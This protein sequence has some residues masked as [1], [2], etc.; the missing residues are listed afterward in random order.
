MDKKIGSILFFIS[1]MSTVL[2]CQDQS[3]LLYVKDAEQNPIRQ[4]EK[5]VPFLFQVVVNSNGEKFQK[6]EHIAGMDNFTVQEA[7]DERSV[8][9]ING[10]RSERTTYNYILK[11]NT[12]GSFKFG[13]VELKNNKGE[14]IK[15]EAIRFHV[16][17]QVVGHH[18]KRQPYFLQIDID[19]KSLYVG[20]TLVV[21]VR[22]Y[23]VEEFQNLRIVKPD[24]DGFV[25][26]HVTKDPVS[27]TDKIHGKEYRYQEWEMK[28]YPEK[29]GTIL[30]PPYQAVFMMPA[31]FAQGLMGVFDMLSMSS[32]RVVQSSARSVD[33]IALPDSAAFKD[34]T[35]VGD[36]DKASLV[37]NKSEGDV[38]EGLVATLSVVGNGNVESFKAPALHL[39]NGL[40]YYESN[41]F[42]RELIDGKHEKAFEY[43]LQA[44]HEGDFKVPEQKFSYFD[45]KKKEYRSLQTSA[46][47]LKINP[48]SLKKVS[49][50]N[51]NVNPVE[52]AG[53]K[54]RYQFKE[55][56]L[57]FVYESGFGSPYRENILHDVFAWL[58]ILFLWAALFTVLYWGYSLY[59]GI[60]L[61]DIY[62]IY[63]GFVYFKALQ[64]RRAQDINGLYLLL[65]K[66]GRRYGVDLFGNDLTH[67]LNQAAKKDSGMKGWSE[68]LHVI[69]S[70][71]F[72]LD[73]KNS[74]SQGYVLQNSMYWLQG[75]L[76]YVRYKKLTISSSFSL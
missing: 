11:G 47:H 48:S 13:P 26:E 63:Y 69:T 8:T 4:A 1:F 10:Q 24:L 20:E 68:F 2:L 38:G 18:V 66:V 43:V 60:S 29:V 31:N 62:W 25:V 27:G 40:K 46:V 76:Y 75:L 61:L 32:E 54:Q 44:D 59:I 51:D 30:I 56:E 28:L 64:L 73:K 16:G 23:F 55:G 52:P 57:D 9:I 3:V 49:V 6:P 17:D 39:P 7:Q 37:I 53:E 22:F 41:S 42:V 72:S 58:L 33:V 5:G 45:L 15:S 34:V 21:K 67:F 12:S 14:V 71:S 65:C 36:F 74:K 50:S 35:A 19:K 70:L